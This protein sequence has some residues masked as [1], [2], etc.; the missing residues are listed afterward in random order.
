M[1]R[2]ASEVLFN[3]AIL[4]LIAAYVAPEDWKWLLAPLFL[5]SSVHSL[6]RSYK[7]W[8]DGDGQS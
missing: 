7:K 4:W 3:R 5:M 2:V 1:S 6:W 8:G